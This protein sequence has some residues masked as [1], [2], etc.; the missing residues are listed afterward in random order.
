MAISKAELK[1]AFREVASM[2]FAEIPCS[3]EQIVF[4]FSKKFHKKMEKLIVRQ[5]SAFWHMCNT[6]AKKTAVI[7]IVAV[8]LFV[9]LLSSEEIRASMLEWCANVYKEYMEYY[10]EGETTTKIKHEY[11]L[12]MVPDGFEVVYEQRDIESIT[13]CYENEEG[14]A[15]EFQQY[16]T[17]GFRY[18]LD[19]EN[20]TY[21]TVMIDGKEVK[22]YK[23]YELAGAMWIEDGYY[24][25]LIY[26][27]CE[28]LNIIKEMVRTIE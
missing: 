10:F 26:Y 28:D 1:Q 15:I 20:T 9:T 3:E 11:Q 18:V 23:Y 7:V 8:S 27:G 25:W 22:I 16:V 6:M 19:N 2:E 24:L 14:D 12:T 13:T 21:S 17:E 5:Q 4:T